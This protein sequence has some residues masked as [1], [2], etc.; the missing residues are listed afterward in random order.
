[1]RPRSWNGLTDELRGHNVDLAVAERAGLVKP[2]QRG[3]YYDFYRNRLMVPTYGTTGEVIAFGGRE[4]GSGEPE[5]LN[6]STTPVYTKGEHLYALNVARRA[7]A[8][9]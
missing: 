2:S 4:L 8:S 7:A 6:T 5:T 1:M 3:G 9:E